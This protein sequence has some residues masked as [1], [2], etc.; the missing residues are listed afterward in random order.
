MSTCLFRETADLFKI[1]E[2]VKSIERVNNVSWAEEVQDIPSK[3]AIFS[4]I[5][6]ESIDTSVQ[7]NDTNDSG[8]KETAP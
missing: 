4:F 2:S 3:E 7:E 6:Q 1:I 8:H 5:V